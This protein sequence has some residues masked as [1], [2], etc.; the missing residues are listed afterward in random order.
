MR[1]LVVFLTLAGVVAAYLA[2]REHYRTEGQA[3]CSI[4]EKW[5][6]GTVNKSRFASIGGVF[7][8]FA[9][10]NA[11]LSDDAKPRFE[12]VRKIPVA[13]V[14]IAGYI[15]LGLLALMRRWRLLATASVLAWV[16][17]LYLAHIE[18]DILEVWCVYCVIS[19]GIITL[20]MVLSLIS[21][22]MDWRRGRRA[23]STA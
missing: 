5:D 2:L 13:D 6:C 12:T 14:G 8:Q 1:W 22:G 7:D 9:N 20:I 21:L 3:P 4:N 15:L 17:S 18:K 10:R 11:A 16:F 23:A 19:L